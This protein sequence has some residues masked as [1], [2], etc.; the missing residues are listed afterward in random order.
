MIPDKPFDGWEVVAGLRLQT[1]LLRD[2]EIR[3]LIDDN[4]R[5]NAQLADLAAE[6]SQLR[7]SLAKESANPFPRGGAEE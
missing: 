7:R 5:L 3:S 4:V 1:I 6:V 2:A